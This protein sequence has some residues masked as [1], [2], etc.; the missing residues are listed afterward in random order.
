MTEIE[1]IEKDPF[2][3]TL[4]KFGVRQIIDLC[5]DVP[6]NEYT[7]DKLEQEFEKGAELRGEEV[8]ASARR[9]DRKKNFET[10]HVKIVNITGLPLE[11]KI[12]IKAA[13]EFRNLE[14][15]AQTYPDPE[16]RWKVQKFLR[17]FKDWLDYING[18]L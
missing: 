10:F 9:I 3:K 5:I 2:D 7:I 14:R 6:L 1:K 13:I 15:L 11:R 8:I 16:V 17:A 12:G 18:R 4:L